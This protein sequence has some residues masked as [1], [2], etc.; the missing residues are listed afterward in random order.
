MVMGEA[1]PTPVRFTVT[2]V[3]APPNLGTMEVKPTA[4]GFKERLYAPT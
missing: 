2:A 3:P 1:K 4:V